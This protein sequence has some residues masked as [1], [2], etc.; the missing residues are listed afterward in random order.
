MRPALSA[1]IPAVL[2]LLVLT[3][4]SGGG[5]Q[6]SASGVTATTPEAAANPATPAAAPVQAAPATPQA[7]ACT[8]FRSDLEEGDM[9]RIYYATA[10]L[11]PPR[12]KWADRVL[13]RLDR[14]LPPEEAW[15][16]ALAEVDAR[17]N[18]LKDLRCVTLRAN[19]GIRRYDASRGGLLV[20]AFSPEAWY[21]FS[22]SGDNVRLKIRNADAAE[23]W[24]MP[25]DRGQALTA[26]YGLAN[27]SV[28]A[29]LKIVGARPSQNGGV[30]EAEI[31]D[32]D[33]IP[34]SGSRAAQENIRVEG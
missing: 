19:A 4:C 25:A 20:E 33:V 12:E 15:N 14:S 18:A 32:Y 9:V 26:N 27:S 10:G 8:D 7:V 2:S 21:D 24:K 6:Q 30:I 31:V 3:A 29:R 28:V 23:L 16:R 5:G 17:W 22:D 1:A 34:G 11:P 13:S